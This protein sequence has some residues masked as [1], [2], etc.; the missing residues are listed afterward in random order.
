MGGGNLYNWAE[1][2]TDS[3]SGD[4]FVLL[5]EDAHG[6]ALISTWLYK[7]IPKYL[8]QQI[9]SD[10]GSSENFGDNPR[11]ISQ[12]SKISLFGDAVRKHNF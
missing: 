1:E 7:V 8:A 6:F 4:S 11:L 3:T 9:M 5:S 10:W 2:Y 12:Q